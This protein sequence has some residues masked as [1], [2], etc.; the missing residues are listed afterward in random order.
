MTMRRQLSGS[1]WKTFSAGTVSIM[2]ITGMA[3][4]VLFSDS[5]T[6]MK[7]EYYQTG[8]LMAEAP[9]R[10][11]KLVGTAKVYFKNGTVRSEAGFENDV[12][13]G[14]T[15]LYYESGAVGAEINFSKGKQHGKTTFYFENG[16]PKSVEQYDAGELM[17][18]RMYEPAE[19]SSM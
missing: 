10:N 5:F 15:R 18:Q 2:M 1:T 8:E 7:K 14:L 6:G 19:I 17:D 12:L 16:L 4:W 11:G 13:N 3:Y 9:Y